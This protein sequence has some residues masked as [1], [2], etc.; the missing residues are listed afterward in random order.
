MY[1]SGMRSRLLAGLVFIAAMTLAGAGAARAAC[2]DAIAAFDKA[3]LERQMDA[4]ISAFDDIGDSPR[5]ECL[6][7]LGEYRAKLIDFLV[8][9]ANTPDLAADLRDKTI[10]KAEKIAES[11]GHWQGKA[12]IADYHFAHSNK[13]KA[14][15]WYQASVVALETP[16][17]APG[18]D[19]ERQDLMTRLAAIRS[20]AEADPADR[21]EYF[22]SSRCGCS[23]RCTAS[24]SPPQ[25]H[26]GM[27]AVKT[28][29]AI[30]FQA[31][32]S[33][34]TPQGEKALQ[35]LAYDEAAN[36]P[37]LTLI[38]HA[39][40]RSGHKQN[41]SLSRRRVVAVRKSLQAMGVKA[42]ITAEWK[43]DKEPFDVTTLPAGARLSE[44][45]T[46]LL[47]DRIEVVLPC[48]AAASPG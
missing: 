23:H 22:C 14:Y 38:G 24:A 2:A 10:D 9:F 35:E 17:A 32:T 44:K 12:R 30:S 28:P 26:Q 41:M 11:S 45:E 42:S 18:T 3:I 15:R 5:K 39:A 48:A 19:K 40:S 36:T 25:C 21:P 6:G 29:T 47:N 20:L 43:G 33:R 8:D 1:I 7:R 37:S 31:N 27:A 4:V 46:G 16:G 34:F 13:W